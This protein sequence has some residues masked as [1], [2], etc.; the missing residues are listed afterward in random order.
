MRHF[1]Y[2]LLLIPFGGIAQQDSL[3]FKGSMQVKGLGSFSYA[4]VFSDSLGLV[5]GYSI[6]D[7]GGPNETKAL[8]KGMMDYKKRILAFSEYK[9]VY[10]KAAMKDQQLCFVHGRL[11]YTEKVDE[12]ERYN[13]SGPFMGIFKQSFALCGKGTLS[14]AGDKKMGR[15]IN[16]QNDTT[17]LLRGI[18]ERVFEWQSDTLNFTIMDEGQVDGD[19]VSIW[20]DDVLIA[21]DIELAKKKVEYRAAWGDAQSI[22]LKIK[23]NNEGKI[24]PNTTKIIF[25]DGTRKVNLYTSLK[26][27]ESIQL[28]IKRK[29]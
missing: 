28:L 17:V 10:T 2:F 6:S 27:G 14:L 13:L 12:H 16:K 7:E 21:D 24:P 9:L 18:K 8:I 26:S 19:R 15:E 22:K 4:L 11:N 1:F 25:V 3:R 5:N 20:K 29:N 23:A